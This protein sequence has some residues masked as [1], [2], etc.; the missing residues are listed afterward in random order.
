M[1]NWRVRIN[2][3]A[4]WML[5]IPALALVVKAVANLL[6]FTL[7]LDPI[8]DKILMVVEAVFALLAII[9]VVNDP[10]TAGLG[11][12]ARAKTY[13]EPWKDEA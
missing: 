8:V 4:F 1:I 9:G 3:K 11:D 7:D 2:N 5:A 6:G 13:V 10:T 12:S